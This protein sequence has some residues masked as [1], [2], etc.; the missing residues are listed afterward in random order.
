[1]NV[2]IR[3][4]DD[5]NVVE[6]EIQGNC[7]VDNLKKQIVESSDLDHEGLTLLYKGRKMCGDADLDRYSIE[8]NDLLVLEKRDKVD[9]DVGLEAVEDARDWLRQNIVTSGTT[10][11]LRDYSL[12]EEGEKEMIFELES[13][14]AKLIMSGGKIDDYGLVSSKNM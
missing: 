1:M 14:M 11:E 7:R 10:V 5:E 6:V 12:K 3:F 9:P 8:D 4:T 2:L 13:E